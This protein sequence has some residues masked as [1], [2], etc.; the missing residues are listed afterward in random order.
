[1]YDI[2]ASSHQSD[3]EIRVRGIGGIQQTNKP[4]SV[5]PWNDVTY[6]ERTQQQQ[7]QQPVTS[8]KDAVVNAE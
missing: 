4:H 7:Q 3:S 6:K 2:S 5:G 8:N 1:M